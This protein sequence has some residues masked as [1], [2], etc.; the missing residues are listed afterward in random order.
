[1]QAVQFVFEARPANPV[2]ISW[3]FLGKSVAESAERVLL[4]GDR[5]LTP[6]SY[7]EVVRLSREA[8][9]IAVHEMWILSYHLSAV[10]LED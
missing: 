7:L 1:M 3:T 9:V 8:V 2:Q 4:L 5:F 6:S 10:L